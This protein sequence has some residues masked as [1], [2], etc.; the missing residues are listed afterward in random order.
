MALPIGI[1]AAIGLFYWAGKLNR[2]ASAVYFD[3]VVRIKNSSCG[4][5]AEEGAW[6]GDIAGLYELGV[7]SREVAEA[8][9]APLKPLVDRPRPYHGYFVV[10]M[11]SSASNGDWS[12]SDTLKGK[13]RSRSYG[14]CVY[15]A[16]D[17]RPDLP[18]YLVHPSGIHRKASLGN[19][20]ILQ[21][22]KDRSD[23]SIVD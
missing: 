21:W 6:N 8:D 17:R 7:I 19:K 18:V 10:A 5:T 4:Y 9:S 11:E 2:D 1:C 13:L 22:P 12:Q 14:V 23:W 15:P 16:E 20:P 3:V